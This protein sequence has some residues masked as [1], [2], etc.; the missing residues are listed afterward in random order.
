M[1]QKRTIQVSHSECNDG[2]PAL[3]QIFLVTETLGQESR[4]F[5]LPRKTIL[6]RVQ[7]QMKVLQNHTL[8]AL[9]TLREVLLKNTQNVIILESFLA[10]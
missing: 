6:K 7:T 8:R 3:W 2:S 4:F 9:R 10:R 1:T 5:A